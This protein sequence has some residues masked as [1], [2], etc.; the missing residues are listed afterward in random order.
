MPRTLQRVAILASAATLAISTLPA[1]VGAQT[2]Y[3]SL[4]TWL[5]AVG[6]T[7]SWSEDFSSF[8][9]D[10]SFLSSAVNTSAFSLQ[11]TNSGRVFRNN[12]D[13]PP[14]QFTDNN[15]TAYASMFTNF[16]E[17][18]VNLRLNQSISAWGAEFFAARSGEAVLLDLFSS[19]DA[20]LSSVEVSVN[21]GFFGFV[22]APGAAVARIEFRSATENPGPGG[23]GFGMDNVTGVTAVAVPEPT[24]LGLLGMGFL[25]L[26]AAT[27]RRTR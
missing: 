14:V 21:S 20:L 16:G 25:F 10:E 2:T 9:S 7:A 12:I 4:A 6:G 15:G 18:T 11:A 8:T 23:E 26:G 22:M 17:Q 1:A 19:T 5:A 3:T 27:R 24:T 13:V